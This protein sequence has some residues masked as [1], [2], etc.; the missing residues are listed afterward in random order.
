MDCVV[1]QLYE[2]VG[3]LSHIPVEM[4]RIVPRVVIVQA[5]LSPFNMVDVMRQE[6]S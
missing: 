2:R 5:A 6:Q 1:R 3:L 4:F